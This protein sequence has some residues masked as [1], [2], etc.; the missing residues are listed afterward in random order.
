[1][2]HGGDLAA[3]RAHFATPRSR[4]IDLSTGI[5]PNAYPVGAVTGE[6]WQRLPQRDA[7]ARLLAAAR[8]AYAL[9]EGGA[10]VAAPGTQM[11]IQLA[12]RLRPASVV[13]VVGPTYNEHATSWAREGHRVIS[14]DN[15]EAGVAD[16]SVVVVVNPN[17]PD[18]RTWP[19]TM[20]L[21]AADRLASNGGLLVVDE[22]FADVQPEGSVCRWAGRD[23]L[24][25]MRS[26]GKFYGL[27]GVRL[28]F[29]VGTASDM[30]RVAGWLGPW[31]V[32]GPALAI[33]E[34]A[35]RD[36]TWA[37]STRAWID[38]AGTRFNA[39]LA[40]LGLEVI[41]DAGLFRL[42]DHDRARDL[43]KGLAEHGI[44][45]RVFDEQ[46]NWLRLGLPAEADEALVIET[47]RCVIAGCSTSRPAQNRTRT[48]T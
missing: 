19:P 11:L 9:P 22:A 32:S 5:N 30:A 41:G 42:I 6:D 20:L 48:P 36:T 28:G 1:M 8:R 34:T 38:V 31:S 16:T 25:V 26:F 45:T 43:H 47:L 37:E 21:E 18:G 29:G 4:W 2:R 33:G 40:K 3:A 24:L 35:L 10:I 23:G 13:A 39:Q 14:V 46:P 12:A 15:L 17:N 27:A 7:E 44:W